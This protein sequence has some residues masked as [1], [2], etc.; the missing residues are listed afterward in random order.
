MIA[1]E[2]IRFLDHEARHCREKDA[3]EA[4]CLLLP[5]MMQLL[6]LNQM[7]AFEALSFTI[8]FRDELRS[9][10]NPEPVKEV[11][12]ALEGELQTASAH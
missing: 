10:V 7:D 1:E 11:P 4:L 12:S 3:H 5:A 2:A 6:G 8:E 9:Q